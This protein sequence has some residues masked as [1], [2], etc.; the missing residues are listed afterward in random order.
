MGPGW[1]GYL[2]LLPGIPKNPLPLTLFEIEEPQFSLP[3][4]PH[5]SHLISR[6]S[7]LFGWCLSQQISNTHTYNLENKNHHPTQSIKIS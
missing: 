5:C 6:F 2:L 3:V 4:T 7:I 1:P